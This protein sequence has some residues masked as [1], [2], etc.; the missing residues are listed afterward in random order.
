MTMRNPLFAPGNFFRDFMTFHYNTTSEADILTQLGMYAGALKSILLDNPDFITYKIAHYLFGYNIT[1]DSFMLYKSLGGMDSGQFRADT[2][3]LKG[4]IRDRN[5]SSVKWSDMSA[6]DFG[7][8]V[9]NN[10]LGLKFLWDKYFELNDIFE[11]LPRLAEFKS[12][13]KQTGDVQLSMYRAQD[14]TTNFSRSGSW[15]RNINSI[16]LFSNAELQGI[17]KMVRNYTEA[18]Y[19]AKDKS[20]NPVKARAAARVL[21]TVGWSLFM[22]ALSEF[23]NRRDEEAEEEYLSLIHI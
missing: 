13:L 10:V 3:V 22:V 14:V 17:D 2:D 20:G 18:A 11:T 23:I 1:D 9:K 19:E 8:K 6:R 15:G 21:K 12:T 7:E 4:A 5:T 16:F